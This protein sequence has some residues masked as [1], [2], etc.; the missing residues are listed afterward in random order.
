MKTSIRPRHLILTVALASVVFTLPT[1]WRAASADGQSKAAAAPSQLSKDLMGIWV[2]VG[3][4]GDAGQPPAK[5]GRYKFRTGGHW[6]LTHADPDTGLVVEHFGG[7]YTLN[8]NEYVETQDYAD[9]TWLRDNGK[10]WKYTVKVEGNVM[11]QIGIGNPYNE[12]WRRVE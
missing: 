2:H 10:S 4:P 1:V 8:G 3:R 7:T 6:T 9:A 12:V 11:T 5:G